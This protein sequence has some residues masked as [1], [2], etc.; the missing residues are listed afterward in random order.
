MTKH[1]NF[2]LLN[3][4]IKLDKENP[5]GAIEDIEEGKFKD[6]TRWTKS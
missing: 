5:G 6:K 2:S 3:Y 4:L 1:F